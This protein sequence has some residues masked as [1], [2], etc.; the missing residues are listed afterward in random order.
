MRSINLD[1]S[2]KFD[3]GL[4]GG[5]RLR[6]SETEKTVNL[7]HDYM[8]ESDSFPEAAPG[9]ASGYFSAGVAHYEK[10]VMIPAEWAGE[11]VTLE[12]D[13]AMMNA[14]VEVNGDKAALQHYGYAPF[15][16]NITP[17]IYYGEENRI[18]VVVNPSMQPNCRWYSGAGIF[19][20][21]KLVHTPRLH[22]TTDGIFAWTAAVEDNVATIKTQ[23]EIANETL[24]N[25][26]AE[27]TVSL[28]PDGEEEAVVSR[29]S[30]VQINPCTK[31]TAYLVLT[32]ENPALW[33]AENP[34]LYKV[35]A[36]V[37]NMGEF[38]THLI[39]EENGMVDTA[40]V[41]F[42]IRTITVDVRH[43]LRI[44]GKEVK[45]KGGCL[46]HDNGLLGAVSVYDAEY[47][48]L[49]I[50]KSIGFNAVRTTHN[51][52]SAAFME[53]CDRLGVYVFDEAFDAWG[54]AKQPGDYNQF[55]ETDWQKD[56]TAFVRR[57]RS[58]PSVV[59]WS[60][61]N[62][63]PER[64][65]LNNGY[66]LATRLAETMR[67]LDPSRPV[68]N[69][70]CSFWNGLDDY[71]Q[72]EMAKKMFGNM[73]NA[74]VAGEDISWE[75]FSEG[76]TNGLDIVGYNYMEDKYLRDHEMFPER[77]ILGSE[78]FP[79][80]IG[81]RWPLVEAHPWI[82]G[83]FTWTAYDYIGEAGIGKSVHVDPDDPAASALPWVA[84]SSHAS[85]FP[86]RLAN[87]ADV[88]ITGH[89]LPQGDYRSVVWG[90]EATFVY[91]YDPQY[92][93]KKEI[94][95]MWGFADVR[96]SWNWPGQEGKPVNLAVFSRAEEVEVLVNGRS[97][98]RK[99]AGEAIV[100][101][102][103]Q[104]FL[105]AAVYEPGVVEA[106]SYV[107]GQEVSRGKIET[108]GAPCA[109][110]L[111]ADKDSIAADGH[112]LA[113]VAVEVVDAEGRVVPDAALPLTAEL[114][115]EGLVLAGFGS[116]NPVT[117][118]NYTKGS[119]TSYRGRA[120][121]VVRSEYAVG[122]AVLTI[123][124]EGLEAVCISLKSH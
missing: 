29:T 21:L 8:I 104:S 57:D 56:L 38:R 102:L 59:I 66:T 28:I 61:G 6:P 123:Q 34:N 46:H 122:E 72:A 89:I 36:S 69:A 116:G 40:E 100:G 63:I 51:P 11:I 13:G 83:D 105:F 22:V 9:P 7:P 55:F 106:I 1:Q 81:F 52:P 109:L 112:S 33:D 31:D 67:A 96:R 82:L 79:K 115:G 43:G 58:H 95:S 118:E 62:E 25:R 97:L 37:K 50:L 113:Y 49:S 98:G 14:T 30:R 47:R 3:F 75:Q 41:L 88:D 73:Q 124:A 84:L 2:W 77:I 87:D 107:G 86:W 17:Y 111:K 45:L 44:N 74:D 92:F 39:P 15:S 12:F 10:K 71:L 101:A 70:I 117:A 91:S 94:L 103:P 64:G 4:G 76:F 42:G 99:K 119:F 108:V 110:R 80:E 48:K 85:V 54:I 78:N 27:V 90:N 5:P 16:V 35:R 26:M 24:E 20:S 23:V 60:T 120:M 114:A 93:G 68:S 65:G 18:S 32:V 19:R 121:A 53:A